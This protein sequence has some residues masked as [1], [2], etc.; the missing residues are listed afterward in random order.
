[1]GSL[2]GSFS[3]GAFAG[4]LDKK[5]CKS[6]QRNFCDA[7]IPSRLEFQMDVKE[8]VEEKSYERPGG[9]RPTIIQIYD[10]KG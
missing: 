2:L 10:W 3:T 6:L 7:D 9:L 8:C 4:P 1:M 5:G